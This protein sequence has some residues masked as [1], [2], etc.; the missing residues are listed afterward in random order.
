MNFKNEDSLVNP[1]DSAD[2]FLYAKNSPKSE[3]EGTEIGENVSFPI[4]RKKH[5]QP[6]DQAEKFNKTLLGFLINY[7]ESRGPVQETS[8]MLILD[9]H[10]SELRSSCGAVYKNSPLKCLNGVCRMP[11]FHVHNGT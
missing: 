1:S 2:Y 11:I 9:D 8:L 4:K 3:L 5:K 10:L 7:L 6:T